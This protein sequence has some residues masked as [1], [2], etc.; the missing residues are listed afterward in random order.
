ML[1]PDETRG[2][3]AGPSSPIPTLGAATTAVDQYRTVAVST[4]LPNLGAAFT[5]L[6]AVASLARVAEGGISS[7][8][9][10]EAAETAL[11]ALLLHDI[12][13][14]LVPAPKFKLD[15][16]LVS[17]VRHDGTART[18]FGFNLF[19]LAASRDFLVAPERLDLD[20]DV[21][22]ASTLIKSPLVGVTLDELRSEPYAHGDVI[23]A[24]NVAIESHGIPAYLTDPLLIRSRRGDGFAKRFYHRIRQPWDKAVGDIPPIVCTFALPPLLAIVLNRAG[25][26]AELRSIIAD[27]RAELAPVRAELRGFNTIVTQSTSQSEIEQR[28]RRITESFDAIFPE[29]RISGAERRSRRILKI[30]GLVRPVVKFAMGFVTRTGASFEDGLGAVNGARDTLETSSVVDRTVTARAFAGMLR[31]E[32]VQSL[33]KHHFSDS[34]IASIE[35]SMRSG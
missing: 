28:V 18:Q 25:N 8:A 27:L 35:R 7:A 23:E 2:F 14:V 19:A 31:T 33:V 3:G 13:H 21:V 1:F 5:D 24:L 10:V 22:T 26:R 4:N 20:G 32:S 11:Q 30:Q 29:S 34:E 6:E 9:Q 12:V 16:G 17:Y 15:N